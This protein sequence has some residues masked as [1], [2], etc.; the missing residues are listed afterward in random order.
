MACLTN[1]FVGWLIDRVFDYT[2]DWCPII[3]DFSVAFHI[4]NCLL[5][6]LIRLGHRPPRKVWSPSKGII[7]FT[8]HEN[9]R[10][11]FFHIFL[12][13][14]SSFA[15][16]WRQTFSWIM[17]CLDWIELLF[18]TSLELVEF[19]AFCYFTFSLQKIFSIT[20]P[21]VSFQ[22]PS[23][24][25][26]S[27]QIFQVSLKWE[28]AFKADEENH[29]LFIPMFWFRFSNSCEVVWRNWKRMNAVLIWIWFQI[30]IGQN[31]IS[32]GNKAP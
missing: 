23:R 15:F 4:I 11:L 1:W 26:T 16:C 25:Q 3:I 32:P 6:S 10:N 31:R 17:S 2:C 29:L 22:F 24:F 8:T 30:K 5:R 13:R 14:V 21:S 7:W 12:F 9:I 20:N 28:T 27:P 19:N 18:I